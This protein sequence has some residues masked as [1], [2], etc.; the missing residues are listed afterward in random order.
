VDNPVGLSLDALQAMT[1]GSELVTNGDFASGTTGFA[2]ASVAASTMSVITGEAQVIATV[3]YG[4]QIQAVTC[5]VGQTY[6]L[7][8]K[9]RVISGGSRAFIGI[10]SAST[11]AAATV[12][13]N[14]TLTTQ[15]LLS[16]QFVADAT[17]MYLV[18]GDD[19]NVAGGTLGFDDISIKQIPGIHASQATTANKPILRRGLLNLLTQAQAY[20]HTDWAK[21][22]VGTASAPAL[23]ALQLAP[24]GTTTAQRV[25]FSCPGTLIGDQSMLD[26]ASITVASGQPYTQIAYIKGTPGQTI[27]FR[28]VAGSSY[29]TLTFDGT[30]QIL[31]RVETSI[32]TTGSWS[33]GLRGTTGSTTG[34]VVVD[35]WTAGLFQGTYTAQQII[36]A[37]GIPLTT[38]VAASNSNSGKYSWQFDGVND[39]LLTGNLGITNTVSVVIAGVLNSLPATT[40]FANEGVNG[41]QILI[42]N[43]GVIDVFK[44]GVEPI[45]S[46][47]SGTIVAGVP[48]VLTFRLQGGVSV[49]RKNGAQ[50]STAA[51][52]ASLSAT[53]GLSISEAGAS[54]DGSIYPIIAIKGTVSD[55]DLLTLER[56]VGQLSG[57]LI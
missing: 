24:D 22:T 17:T 25:T 26:H 7:A 56:F 37:G 9:A 1:L 13:G 50:V 47:A 15:V 46:T 33:I 54:I 28:N 21:Y 3:G 11:G 57:V 27:A 41:L 38:S 49:L 40:V 32:S 20:S 12:V 34:T 2:S 51:Y 36:D 30:W 39:S 45:I 23:G 43:T 5:T 8:G 10:T 18:F 35:L 29:G 42:R 52:V 31:T 48:F 44:A 19:L 6:R 53:A 14:T 16:G 55:A 4:R